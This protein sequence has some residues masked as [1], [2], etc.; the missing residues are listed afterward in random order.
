MAESYV[1]EVAARL[2]LDT[3]DFTAPLSSATKMIEDFGAKIPSSMGGAQGSTDSLNDSVTRLSKSHNVLSDSADKAA[4]SMSKNLRGAIQGVISATGLAAGAFG[5]WNTIQVA[6][7]VEEMNVALNSLGK[8]A[9]LTTSQVKEQ[10]NAIKEMGITT[11]VAQYTMSQFLKAHLDTAQAA[12]LA[13]VAQDAAVYSMSDS[14]TALQ[15]LVYGIQTYQTEIFRTQGL[16]INVGKSFDDYAKSVNKTASDLT[17]GERQQAVMNAVLKEGTTISGTYEAA[18]GTGSKQLRSFARYIEEAQETIG[19]AFL[20]VFNKMVFALAEGTKAFSSLVVEGGALRPAI[21]MLGAAMIL[22]FTVA[23]KLAGVFTRLSKESG[24]LGETL[25]FMAHNLKTVIEVM[26]LLAVGFAMWKIGSQIA[27]W[28]LL[29]IATMLANKELKEHLALLGM[30]ATFTPAGVRNSMAMAAAYDAQAA[31]IDLTSTA[32]KDLIATKEADLAATGASVPVVGGAAAGGGLLARTGAAIGGVVSGAA[33]WLS[34]AATTLGPIAG[35]V[36]PMVYAGWDSRKM[37]QQEA[38][39]K[40][41]MASE[42][43]SGVAGKGDPQSQLKKMRAEIKFQK[44]IDREKY[45]LGR[46]Q[47]YLDTLQGGGEYYKGMRTQAESEKYQQIVSDAYVDDNELAALVGKEKKTGKA[48]NKTNKNIRKFAKEMGVSRSTV[49]ETANAMGIDL[50]T[51]SQEEEAA[52][53]ANLSV[54]NEASLAHQKYTTAIYGASDATKSAT[55]RSDA[56]KNSLAAYI[57][58]VYDGSKAMRGA[59]DSLLTLREAYKAATKSG[60][61][62]VKNFKEHVVEHNTTILN[63]FAASTTAMREKGYAAVSLASYGEK[64]RA[65]ALKDAAAQGQS[66]EELKKY[67]EAMRNVMLI[68]LASSGDKKGMK[69][70]LASLS[71]D[72]KFTDGAAI[73]E[74]IKNGKR[75]VAVALYPHIDYSDMSVDDAFLV[76]KA[77]K[78][79]GTKIDTALAMHFFS[80]M[81]KELFDA[82]GALKKNASKTI[83]QRFSILMTAQFDPSFVTAM[84]MIDAAMAM[85]TNSNPQHNQKGSGLSGLDLTDNQRRQ[86]DVWRNLTQAA[87]DDLINPPGNDDP[88]GG[89]TGNNTGG[90]SAEEIM[91]EQNRM[92][93]AMRTISSIA[94]PQTA[95]KVFN[96]LQKLP[97]REEFA[98]SLKTWKEDYAK[99]VESIAVSSGDAT[100]RIAVGWSLPIEVLKDVSAVV[101]QLGASFT[102]FTK[103]TESPNFLASGRAGDKIDEWVTGIIELDAKGLNPSLLRMLIAAGPESLKTVRKLLRD[104]GAMVGKE[105][106]QWARVQGIEARMVSTLG[107]GKLGVNF[108]QGVVEGMLDSNAFLVGAAQFSEKLL[109]E[110]AK[111]LGIHSPSTVSAEKI[112]VPIVQGILHAI[113]R[114]AP[115]IGPALEDAVAGVDV[116]SVLAGVSTGTNNR[117]SVENH[118]HVAGF[119]VDKTSV[120]AMIEAQDWAM[121]TSGG[122]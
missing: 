34:S 66:T 67:G 60:S 7:R 107:A 49:Q 100:A 115:M 24:L 46:G 57:S 20:P 109:E 11:E 44:S 85:G 14:S 96:T 55:E 116:N 69:S 83:I 84:Q 95:Q 9:G 121:R 117:G 120:D 68:Q 122:M 105:N 81:D 78:E 6:S 48:L 47:E 77:A 113:N 25:R 92:N 90:K 97:E 15:Q 39:Q 43:V 56:A 3:R 76:A 42:Y 73:A 101:N 75:E 91:R 52:L 62:S 89:T 32:L 104:N 51:P 64:F 63:S 27:S 40:K 103:F 71:V 5:I 45:A 88:P 50:I 87:R 16:N 19:T 13:R 86:Y 21:D 118:F 2:T 28:V 65:D 108:T 8:N 38:E 111:K 31:S 70:A 59:Q 106:D 35:N 102:A 12:K 82:A 54:V 33:S 30:E 53:K 36:L 61:D 22:P 18:M 99:T 74:M 114:D 41:D 4:S 1:A 79:T 80:A 26:G 23:E 10:T 98:A 29:K 93:T 119:L 58:Y 110:I 94:V 112:G 72:V 17:E 37:Y